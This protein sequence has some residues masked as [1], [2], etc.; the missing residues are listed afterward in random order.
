VRA[1]STGE[2]G[3]LR[4]AQGVPVEGEGGLV[5]LRLDH[6]PELADGRRLPVVGVLGKGHGIFSSA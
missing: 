3:L 2:G 4:Q 6:Q 1:V 5:V